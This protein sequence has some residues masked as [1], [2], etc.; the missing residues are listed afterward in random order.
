MPEVHHFPCLS[1]LLVYFEASFSFS[2]QCLL[3]LLLCFQSVS[4][5]V[6]SYSV[7]V[8][9]WLLD[10]NFTSCLLHL[11]SNYPLRTLVFWWKSNIYFCTV[12]K[13]T[14][15]PITNKLLWPQFLNKSSPQ[16]ADLCPL[17]LSQQKGLV[18]NL[19]NKI[20]TVHKWSTEYRVEPFKSKCCI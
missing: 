20:P 3:Q 1:C 7:G 11:S 2:L 19:N 18:F 15:L 10:S 16:H 4:C 13:K 14:V 8:L 17:N 12:G 5:C 9:D 6:F